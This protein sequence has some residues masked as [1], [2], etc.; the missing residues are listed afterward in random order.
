LKTSSSPV[1]T[2]NETAYRVSEQVTKDFSTSFYF[3]ARL[4]DQEIRKSIFSIYGFVR[5]AD[6]IVDSFHDYDK[7][8]LLAKFE[9]DYDDAV[10]DGISLNPVLHSFHLTVKKFNI[11]DGYIRAF[12]QSMRYDLQ[13]KSYDTHEEM[14]R[15]IYGSADVVGLMC[16]KVFCNG[17]DALFAE[18][19]HP[20]MKLGSAFQKVNF[21]RDLR[22]DMEN[23][24]RYYFPEVNKQNFDERKKQEIIDDIESDFRAAYEGIKRL[25]GRSRIAVLVAY[26][27][28]LSLLKKIKRTPASLVIMKRI[29]ISNAIKLFLLLKVKTLS[30][31]GM[32]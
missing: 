27:Y 23:L 6:E 21:L 15:Y 17:N 7:T 8:Q 18:L 10:K 2:F 25:P 3:S 24:D 29:R 13:R 20:A 9:S 4:F 32:I 1:L 30:G 5:F 26:Y 28:Y 22:N 12:L 19:E 31:L 11:P 14:S 16:L